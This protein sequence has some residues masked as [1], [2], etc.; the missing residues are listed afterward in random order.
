MF[1]VDSHCHLDCLDYENEHRNLDD[2]INKAAGRDVR[3]MLAVATT[4][5]GFSGLKALVSDRPEIALSCGVHPLNMEQPYEQATLLE[6]ASDPRVVAL[7]KPDWTIFTR[8]KLHS[9]S[10]SSSLSGSIS[11]LAGS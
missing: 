11:A 7:G 5:Q 3:F 1:L 6:L 9:S 8:K 10:N 4:L 2:V